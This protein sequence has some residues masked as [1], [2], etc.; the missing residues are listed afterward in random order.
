MTKQKNKRKILII[1]SVV[2]IAALAIGLTVGLSSAKYKTEKNMAGNVKF[3]ATLAQSIELLEHK[4]TR[5]EDGSY[6]LE[7]ET[8]GEGQTYM[9]MPGVDIPKDPYIVVTGKTSIPA[10]LY[11]EVFAYATETTNGETEVVAFPEEVTY[12]L[13]ADWEAVK[14]NGT[15][16]TGPNGGLLFY[17]KNKLPV[18]VGSDATPAPESIQYPILKTQDADGNTLIVS[19]YIPRGTKATIEFNAYICQ[20]VDDDPAKD[21]RITSEGN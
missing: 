16:K 7:E 21:F 11:V 18:A 13:T 17:Y 1:A 9:L 14:V 15:Q 10:W 3:S 4:A 2:L 5:G 8:T 19:Q 20:V 6:T 12:E